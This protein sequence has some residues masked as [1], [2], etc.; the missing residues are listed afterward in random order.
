MDGSYVSTLV[1]KS[2]AMGMMTHLP[3]W[4]KLTAKLLLARLPLPYWFWRKLGLFRHGEMNSPERAIKTF[5]TYY[6]RA[7]QYVSLPTN[8]ESL[9]LGPGDSI[10]SGLVAKAYGAKCAWLVDAGNFATTELS[11][12]QKTTEL[13]RQQGKNLPPLNVNTQTVQGWL[14]QSDI[15][16]LT[17]GTQSLAQIADAS[18]DFIWSQVVLEHV[19]KSEFLLLA[20]ELRRI[21][22]PAGIGVHSIDFRDHLGGGLNNLR[23]DS[24]IWESDYFYTSG[25]Y[26][27]RLRPSE[28]L[29]IFKAAG[30][31]VEI[32]KETRWPT[33]PLARKLMAKEFELFADED[34][35]VA[36]IE[37]IL[38][39]D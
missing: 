13:L 18:V 27:N 25:F 30:F 16:Y 20:K 8:F 14:E 39:P 37:I 28:I 1:G 19:P 15:R 32:T 22:K 6:E 36:E 4:V 24:S 3:W 12:V 9:E 17:N 33:L 2:T 5:R 7:C 10:L 38:K 23:F 31:V 34:F 11:I 21:I 35:I 29:A 26:T